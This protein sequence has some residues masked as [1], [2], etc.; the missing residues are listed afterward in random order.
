MNFVRKVLSRVPPIRAWQTKKELKRRFKVELA[1]LE[2]RHTTSSSHRSIIHF[3]VN[4]AATQYVKSILKRCAE[5]NGLTHVRINDYA[6]HTDFPYLD[7][8]T[9]EEMQRYQHVFKPSGY[10]YS[11]FG[12]M[13]EGIDDLENYLVVLMVRDPRD[14]LT[15]DYFSIAHSH[16]VPPGDNKVASFME[17]REFARDVDIDRYVIQQ[18]EHVGEIYRCY[19]ELLVDKPNVYITTYE[20]MID[21]FESWLEHLL[22]YCHLPISTRL[23]R[24]LLEEARKSRPEKEDPSSHLRQVTPGDHRRKLKPETIARL[25][26]ELSDVLTGF[27]YA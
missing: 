14:V 26:D 2:G 16:P 20:D 4:K 11:V 22:D 21:D 9:R 10:L 25:N 7:H 8:L 13:V 15:S 1:L 3:S 12:G 5:E 17:R 6:F 18:S 24:E 27:E 19:L 23:E